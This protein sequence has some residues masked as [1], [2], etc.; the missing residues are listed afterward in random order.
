MTFHVTHPRDHLDLSTELHTREGPFTLVPLGDGRSSVVWM[1][2]A[3]RAEALMAL[4]DAAFARAATDESHALL[5]RLTLGQRAGGDPD[6]RLSAERL[7]KGA[8]ALGGGSAC[9]SADRA[10]G[11]NLGL[12]DVRDLVDCLVKERGETGRALQAYEGKR[13][14]DVGVRT[15]AVDVMKPLAARR[16]PAA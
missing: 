3:E 15:A 1:A 2:K 8:V 7:A 4:D 14:A 11:L 10:Q 13:R 16:L 9:L 6:G 12:R 5:G